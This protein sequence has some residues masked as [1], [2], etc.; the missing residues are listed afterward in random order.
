MGLPLRWLS[1][2]HLAL[3]PILDLVVAV[4]AQFLLTPL[5]LQRLGA[6]EFGVWIIVQ[7][8]LLAST[9]LSLGA[10]AGLLPVLSAT[11]SRGDIAGA[12]A[13]MRW[14]ARR[15][16][17]VSSMVLACGGFVVWLGFMLSGLAR[18]A[19]GDT[20]LIALATLA[21]MAASEFDNGFSSA[22]KARGCFG[23]VAQVE[24]GARIT[25]V[26]LI[27][28]LVDV[29]S[30]ALLTILIS[31]ALTVIKALLK[32]YVTDRHDQLRYGNIDNVV[33]SNE[34]PP[35]VVSTG[36]WIWI[37]TLGS[38]AF[39]AFDRWFIGAWFGTSVLASYAI[40]TQIAQMP[41]TIASAAGQVLVPW[42]AHRESRQWNTPTG[43]T[44][45]ALLAQ[46]TAL[47]LVPSALLLP[48]L[49][50]LLALWIS[51]DFALEHL[52][53]ARGLTAVFLLLSFSVPSY[54]LLLGMGYA[55][56]TTVVGSACGVLFVIGVLTL[57][58]SLT[59]FVA[60]KGLFALLTLALPASCVVLLGR[61]ARR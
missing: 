27:F 50:P 13:A 38:L 15:T 3:W 56:L 21:W 33:P 57:P 55:R 36:I 23:S 28:A 7:S 29:G 35:G 34:V 6:H 19:Q 43:R 22:L 24:S 10:S 54:F 60:L 42:A 45:M 44:P 18:A 39:N 59:T 5:L 31:L 25:Q 30:T 48:S 46:T 40:C 58:P 51:K 2:A 4:S 26:V 52:A 20:W 16:A 61:R 53:L 17:F 14:F 12:R 9:A 8:T 49:E 11:L 32:H 47:S 37:G 41:H 1:G